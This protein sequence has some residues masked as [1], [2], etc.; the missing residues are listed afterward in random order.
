[1]CVCVCELIPVCLSCATS[2]SSP[3]RYFMYADDVLTEENVQY[4][5][6]AVCDRFPHLCFETNSTPPFLGN[7]HLES[8]AFQIP[9][10]YIKQVND[11]FTFTVEKHGKQDVFLRDKSSDCF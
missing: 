9:A 8:F 6:W 7:L 4:A 5:A 3:T 11:T 2:L 10:S 1:M